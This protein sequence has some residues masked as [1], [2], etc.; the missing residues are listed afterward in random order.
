MK[1][2]ERVIVG[3]AGGKQPNP[4]Y[5]KIKDHT[6]ALFIEFNPQQVTYW[7]ILEMWLDYPWKLEPR[8]YRSAILF[9]SLAQQ[10]EALYFLAQSKSNERLYA[11]VELVTKF[12][13]AEVYH[14]NYLAKRQA[15]TQQPKKK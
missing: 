2:V 14:Q 15:Q 7:Q 5:Y 1:G 3:Y 13:Q 10:D 9:T 11:D 6:E 4:T 12:Y 8:Q